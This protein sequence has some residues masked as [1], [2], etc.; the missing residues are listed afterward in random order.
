MINSLIQTSY[1]QALAKL[2]VSL[3]DI[4]QAEDYLQS[5]VEQAL[6]KWPIL[7][8][9]NTVAWS[10]KV[11]RNKYIDDYRKQ[12]KHQTFESAS[13]V[14]VLPDLSEEGLLLSYNDDL[15]RLI[16]TCCHPA[17]N[18]ETQIQLALKHVLG[19]NLVQIANA[20]DI[21]T[22]TLEKRL[23]RAKT[24]IS[25]NNIKYETPKP[26]QWTERL[27]GVLKTIYFLFNEGYLTT[28]ASGFIDR[29]LCKEAIRLARLLHQCIKDDPEVMGL[30]ALLL[31]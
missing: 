21:S 3:K 26:Q 20:L 19:L 17:L 5:A 25:V 23:T 6:L 11:A 7:Q 31:Q 15:L 22:K 16:F 13:E 28:E 14:A 12:Q 9:D 8:P 29:D 30:L 2:I 10:V 1:A 4:Q 27:T 18:Q 24:K